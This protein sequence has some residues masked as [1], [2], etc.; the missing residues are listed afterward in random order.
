MDNDPAGID[1]R[2][3]GRPEVGHQTMANGPH[4]VIGRHSGVTGYNLLA[5]R[6]QF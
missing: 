2:L 4:Q 1:D 6:V 5:S 3:Q